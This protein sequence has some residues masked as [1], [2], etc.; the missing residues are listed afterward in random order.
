MKTILK[1]F[2]ASFLIYFI[3]VPGLSYVLKTYPSLRNLAPP[4][5]TSVLILLIRLL[6]LFAGIRI[7]YTHNF[8]NTF[9]FVG[10]KKPFTKPFL[11]GLLISLPFA[12]IW[13]A[14]CIIYKIP[15]GFSARSFLALFLAFMGPGLWEEGVFRGIVFREISSVS[16]WYIAA[17]LTGLFF[18]PAHIANLL[19]GHNLSEI[20]IS[21]IAGFISSFPLGY[22]FY[23]MK[24]NL[25]TCVSFHFFL[26]GFQDMLIT[27]EI[28]KSHLN[29]L[30][31]GIVIGLGITFALIF[32][33]FSSNK[34][35]NFSSGKRQ[36]KT[37][38]SKA[39]NEGM[40]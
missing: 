15:I 28:I 26:S 1:A 17:L 34:F 18:G 39:K 11:I 2:Y 12:I 38:I 31:P 9:S 27:E 32:I 25:W 37:E 4:A 23:R 20:F 3:S 24:G 10:L 30:I 21:L 16:K 35:V 5:I 6:I 22:I 40:V 19:I 29:F 7:F 33:L 14:G 36:Q 13:T 8:S